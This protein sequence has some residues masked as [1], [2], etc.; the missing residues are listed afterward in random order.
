MRRGDALFTRRCRFYFLSITTTFTT[1][2]RNN[3]SCPATRLSSLS[4][5]PSSFLFGET[6]SSPLHITRAARVGCGA[7][8]WTYVVFVFVFLHSH[9]GG[10]PLRHLRDGVV[11]VRTTQLIVVDS[12][13]RGG[14]GGSR[15]RRRR[16]GLWNGRGFETGL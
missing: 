13:V 2:L 1:S 4:P 10:S 9:Y 12:P 16:R 5:P 3:F 7:T 11:V 6:F 14:L 15:R 8:A